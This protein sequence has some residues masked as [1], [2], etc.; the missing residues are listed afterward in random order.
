[1][2]LLLGLDVGTTA[3]KAAGAIHSDFERKFIRAE[4]APCPT[5]RV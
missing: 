5:R 3:V 2:D 4:V 1:M